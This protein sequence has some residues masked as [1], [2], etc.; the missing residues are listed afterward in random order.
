MIAGGAREQLVFFITV[1]SMAP[2][3]I[4]GQE[5]HCCEHNPPI[6]FPRFTFRA[7]LFTFRA[8]RMLE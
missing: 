7:G 3:P 4:A 5:Q 1:A 6:S 2:K 8:R